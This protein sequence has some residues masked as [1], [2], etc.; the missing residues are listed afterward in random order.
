ML[1]HTD[2]RKRTRIE[3]FAFLGAFTLC[4]P[5]ANWMIMN[6]GTSCIE[7]GPCLIP[8]APNMLAPSGVIVVG[9]ALIFRDLVQRRLGIVWCI[10]AIFLGALLSAF[11][12]PPSLLLASGAAFLLSELADCA[13]YTPL[14]RKRFVLAVVASGAIGIVVDSALFLHLAFG[15]MEFLI[16]QIIGKAWVIAL[17]IPIIVWLRAR[18]RKLGLKPA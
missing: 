13:I 4:I 15:N 3:G 10:T 1:Y 8:V 2:K 12:A 5:G 14:Q 18:D 9:L 11:L 7:N 17:A 16:P 6:V